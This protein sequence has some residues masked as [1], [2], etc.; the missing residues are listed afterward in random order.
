[1]T[2]RLGVDQQGAQDE[3]SS[4]DPSDLY[5]NDPIAIDSGHIVQWRHQRLGNCDH[6]TV[7]PLNAF[8]DS[9]YARRYVDTPY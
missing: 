1:M 5:G 3:P 2:P 4:H 8:K 7:D 6:R 9:E